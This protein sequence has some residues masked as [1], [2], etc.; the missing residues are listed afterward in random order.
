MA[1]NFYRPSNAV[2]VIDAFSPLTKEI[3]KEANIAVAEVM[4]NFSF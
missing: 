3:L 4:P 2:K 1:T